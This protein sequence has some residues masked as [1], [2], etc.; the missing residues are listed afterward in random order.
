MNLVSLVVNVVIGLRNLLWSRQT[1]LFGSRSLS[2]AAAFILLVPHFACHCADGRIKPF[3]LPGHCGS[4]KAGCSGH[5]CCSGKTRCAKQQ[6]SS[7]GHQGKS[8]SQPSAHKAPCCRLV[9][10]AQ[11]PIT[12]PVVADSSLSQTCDSWLIGDT[13]DLSQLAAD[14]WQHA[15]VDAS[16]PPLDLVITQLRLT[17]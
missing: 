12:A 15:P 6:A 8:E 2:F 1:R 4:C 10:E 9:V 11:T 16:P 5:S 14:R 3:C 17:I 7:C 13:A